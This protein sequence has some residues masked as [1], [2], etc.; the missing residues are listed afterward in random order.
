MHGGRDV[1]M[2]VKAALAVPHLNP[3]WRAG[4]PYETGCVRCGCPVVQVCEPRLTAQVEERGLPCA[5]VVPGDT[6]SSREHLPQHVKQVGH[7]AGSCPYTNGCIS[8][9]KPYTL[10]DHMRGSR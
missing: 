9:P 2:Q 4:L 8:R 3:T 5:A 6:L 7:D 1:C 10:Q